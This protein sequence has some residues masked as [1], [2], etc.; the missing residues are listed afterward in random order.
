MTLALAFATTRMLK[1]N[2]LVRLLRSCETMGNATVICSDK[3][4]TLTQNQMTAVV[5]F[6]GSHEKFG[7]MP[8]DDDQSSPTALE[9]SS[10]FPAS[11]RDLLVK[12]IALNCT[13]FEEV[14]ENGK[15]F[16]GNKTEVALLRFAREYLG[17]TDLGEE[18]SNA[19]VEHVY[20]FESGRKSMGVVYRTD[21]GGSRLLVKGAAELVLD[22][23]T[24][25]VATG[26]SEATH[27][28][29]EPISKADHK[30]ISGNIDNYASRSLRT[31]GLAYRDLSEC[32]SGNSVDHEK[33]LPSYEQL[34]HDMT[35]IGAFGIQDPLRP[36]VPGAIRKCHS[37]G[38]QVKM[39]TGQSTWSSIFTS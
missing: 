20:P 17:M 16:I 24:Q 1:E 4:G 28:T 15:Q 38:V 19:D 34:L 21:S 29:V 8:S 31:I 36:E 32:P 27:I 13:A 3:T 30:V 14:Q 22:M 33:G 6:F 35:W 23:S 37:A 5:G 11:F 12:S 7:H 26:Q 39:V 25:M 2:N 9:V 18:K 10:R